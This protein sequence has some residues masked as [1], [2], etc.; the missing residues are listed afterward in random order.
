MQHRR[1]ARFWDALGIT[2]A[3]WNGNDAC[4]LGQRMTSRLFSILT[5]SQC[6]E[7]AEIWAGLRRVTL[8]EEDATRSEKCD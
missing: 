3:L 8:F 2:S 5:D 7:L 6:R 4:T 1:L